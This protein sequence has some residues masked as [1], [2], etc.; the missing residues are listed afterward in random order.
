MMVWHDD[1]MMNI[2]EYLKRQENKMLLYPDMR[3][4]TY[5][6]NDNFVLAAPCT[7]A[8]WKELLKMRQPKF[9]G[10]ENYL[11]FTFIKETYHD[12]APPDVTCIILMFLHTPD[13]DAIATA[14]WIRVV[15]EYTGMIYALTF[16]PAYAGETSLSSIVAR[17]AGV[18]PKQVRHIEI[19]SCKESQ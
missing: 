1:R 4:E 5:D 10:D 14:A 15:E 2:D 16:D 18:N 11:P 7:E 17:V 9:D 12:N 19:I 3:R 6:A 8:E 13:D